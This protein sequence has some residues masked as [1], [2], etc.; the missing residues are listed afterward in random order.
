[1]AEAAGISARSWFDRARLARA[2]DGLAA[3]TAASLP[4]STSATAIL[5]VLWLAAALPVLDRPTLRRVLA[6]PAGLLPVVLW[7][8]A[9]VGIAWAGDAT[10][11]EAFRGLGSYHKLLLIPLLMAQ[12]ERSAN[13][14]WVLKA[15]AASCLV[16]LAVSWAMVIAPELV[17][18]KADFAGIPV[19][20]YISQSGLFALS[21]FA[22]LPLADGAWRDKRPVVAA[23]ITAICAAMLANIVYVIT[24][25]TALVVLPVL[26]LIFGLR[27]YGWKGT[28]AVAVAGAAM[29]ALLW[30]SSPYLRLRATGI[31]DEVQSYQATNAMTSSGLRLEFWKKSVSFIADAPVLGHGTG[32]INPL[33]RRAAEGETGA[34]GVAAANPHQQV[35]AVAIQLGAVG[36]ALL[37]ALWLAHGM[38]FWRD[39]FV[40]YCGLLVV[41]QNVVGSQFNSHLFDFTQGW[42]YVIGVGVIGGMV[43]GVQAR[44]EVR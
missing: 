38:L 31:L 29:A 6:T 42:T 12:F 7:L 8:L 26:A 10:W 36:S 33:F 43:R 14:I 18:W 24:A 30:V 37:L 2:A 23:A 3:A 20:D 4:W 35:F 16:L 11:Q 40:A 13:G 22:L 17:W 15:F 39:G 5:I 1:M 28:V 27:W 19:K 21:L 25:R 34:A 32:S 41:V 9:L 44:G